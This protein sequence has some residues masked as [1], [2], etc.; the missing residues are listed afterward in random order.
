MHHRI[1]APDEYEDLQ[2][3]ADYI[4][5]F[6]KDAWPSIDDPVRQIVGLDVFDDCL[7]LLRLAEARWLARTML[8]P[9]EGHQE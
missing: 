4:V 6:E 8:W 3:A 1:F 2:H 9:V 5:P 7:R